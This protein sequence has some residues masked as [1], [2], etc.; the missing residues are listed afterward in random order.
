MMA[1]SKLP[2]DETILA[3]PGN[4]ETDTL[5]YWIEASAYLFNFVIEDPDLARLPIADQLDVLLRFWR[6]RRLSAKQVD[7]EDAALDLSYFGPVGKAVRYVTDKKNPQFRKEF[8][9]FATDP[10]SAIGYHYLFYIVGTLAANAY[11]VGFV[12]EAGK[13]TKKTPD[14]WAEKGGKRTWIEANAKQPVRTIDSPEREWQLI[15]DILEEKKQKFSEAV[16]S[17]GLIVAD[18]SPIAHRINK[19]GTLDGAPLVK[20]NKDCCQPLPG[21]GF[22]C[23]LYDDPEWAARPEN[24][25]N[26]FAFLVQ[27]FATID[28]SKYHVEQCLVT[29]SRRVVS[30]GNN[31]AF[32]RQ[33]QL[34]VTRNA[35]AIALTELSRSLYV[36]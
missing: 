31:L 35:E 19:P 23:R 3:H 14:L 11:Q 15:R 2:V 33:H 13:Q 4:E 32:P 17:P 6:T 5:Q 25:D 27:E 34:I 28:R 22:L 12:A 36:I 29:I 21:G 30:I 7:L 18:I 24:R 9:R 1:Y 10:P 8:K 26:V 20:T 16:Y